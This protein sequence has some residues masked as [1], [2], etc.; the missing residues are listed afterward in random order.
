MYGFTRKT[1]TKQRQQEQGQVSNKTENKINCPYL[2]GLY[3]M[4]LFSSTVAE[5]LHPSFLFLFLSSPLSKT[6]TFLNLY[7]PLTPNLLC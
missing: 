3:G 6:L 4:F 5:I 1:T 2:M 7:T